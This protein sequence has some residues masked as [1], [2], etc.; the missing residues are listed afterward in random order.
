MSTGLFGDQLDIVLSRDIYLGRDDFSV[1][2]MLD[3]WDTWAAASLIG[4]GFSSARA[5]AR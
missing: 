5:V 1:P 2:E 4:G 3:Y